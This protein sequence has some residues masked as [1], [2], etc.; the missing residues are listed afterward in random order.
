MPESET[1]T[2]TAASVPATP[3]TPGGPLFTSLR[4]DSLSHER[5]SFTMARCKCLPSKG[6]TCFTDFSVGVS[7]PNVSLTQKVIPIFLRFFV[8][9]T[10]CI[11]LAFSFRPVGDI[12][13]F[14]SV[15]FWLLFTK[16]K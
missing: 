4:V 16:S 1:G 10:C 14:A 13:Q 15:F 11:F 9:A 3:D 12:V 5:D 6:H 7:L 8:N 2:P